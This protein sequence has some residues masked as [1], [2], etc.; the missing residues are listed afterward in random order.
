[1]SLPRGGGA[2]RGIGEKFSTNPATGTCSLNIP[3]ATSPGRAGFELSLELS[4]DSGSGNGPFGIGWH[5]STPSVSRKTDKG[6]P[7]YADEQDADIFV[8]S[9]AEDLVPVRVRNSDG[10]R[11]DILDRGDYRVQRYRQRTEG[12]FA[13]IERWTNRMNGDVHWRVITRENVLSIYGRSPAARIADPE[14][15]ER[16]FSWLIEETRDDRGNI[17][18]Y[19]YKPE[20][21]TGVDAGRASE[22]N[23][24]EARPDGSREFLATSQRYLKRIQ[25]GNLIPVANREVPAPTNEEDWLFEVVFDYGEHDEATPTPAE[26][27]PWPVREDPFSSFRATFDVRT[28]RLCRRILMFHRFAELGPTPCL[29]RSTDLAYDEGPVVTYL[30]AATQVGYK[31]AP[32]ANVYER[33]MLPPLELGYVKPEVYD[34]LR[35][36]EQ[37]SLEGIPAGI[38]GSAQWVD[39]DGEGIP[40]VLVRTDRTWF[41]KANLGEGRLAPPAL[42]RKLP[43]PAELRR[44]TD[45]LVDLGGDGNLDLVRYLPPLSGYFERTRDKDWAPFIPLTN[46]PNIDWSDPNLRFLDLNGDGLPDVLIT[47]H[48]AFVWYRSKARDGFEPAIFVSKPKDELKGSA[49]VFADRTETIQLAD[50]SGDGL[51]DIVRV[52]NGEVCYWPNL[53]YARFGR[54]VTLDQSPWFDKPDQFDPK[55]IRFADIDGSG[56]S[57]IAYLGREGVYLYFNES[58]NGLS[59]AQRLESLPPIDLASGLSVV[60]LLGRGTA[61]LVWSSPL[62]GNHTRPLTYVDVMG[63]KKPHVLERVVNNLG[64]ET[65]IAYA[66]SNKFYLKDKAEGIPWFTRLAFPVHVVERIERYDHVAN[67]KLVTTFAY[68][69]GYF[70]G[71]EREFRGFARVDQWDA[72]SFSDRKGKGLFPEVPDGAPENEDLDLPPVRTVTWFHTGAWLERERLE[73]ALATEYYGRDPVAQDSR[74]AEFFLPDTVFELGLDVNGNPEQL[75]VREEREAT[76]ALR[77][78]MLRQ[79]IYAEDGTGA[80]E[81]PYLVSER[82]YQVRLIQHAIDDYHGVFFVHPFHSLSLHYERVP[83]DPRIQHE[84]VLKVDAFGNVEKSAD[85]AYPRR[86]DGREHDETASGQSLTEQDRIWSTLTER[87][88]ANRAAEDEWYRI[89]VPV[90]T[91]TSEL[92]GLAAPAQGVLSAD[93]VLAKAAIA[94]EIPYEALASGGVQRRVVERQRAL[95]YRAYPDVAGYRNDALGPLPLGEITQQALPHQVYRQ[96]LTPGLVM[97]IYGTRVTDSM[98]RDEGQYVL[99]DGAWW[100]PSGRAIFDPALFFLAVEAVDPFGERHLLRYDD[101][102]LLVLDAEDPAHNHVTSGLRDSAGTI[103]RNGNDYRVLAPT[104]VCDPNRNRTVVDFDALGMVVKQWQMGREGANEGDGPDTPGVV[105][106]Y[107][108]DAWRQGNGPAFAHVATREVHRVGGD[109]FAQDGTPQR[110]GFQHARSYSDGLGREVMKKVQAE[111]GQVPIVDA[112]GH[113][114]HKPDG[115]PETRREENR[116]VGTGR[117]IF[118]NKGNPIKKYEPFFSG[119]IEYES[120]K[121]LVEWGVTPLLRYD[122]LGR[123][124]RTNQP[125]GTYALVVFD[126]W[127][128]ATWDENDT[129]LS[130]RWYEARGKPMPQ[131]PEPGDAERRAAWLAARHANT[132]SMACLDSL[133]RIFLTVVDNG[134]DANGSARR[135]ATRVKLDVEGNQFSITD[136]RG[137]EI[138][139]HTF[140][141]FARKIRVASVDAGE[142][143]TLFNVGDNRIRAWNPGDYAIRRDYDALQRPLHVWI[144][145][146]AGAEKLVERAVYGEEH[147]DTE[148]RNL[149]ARCYQTYDGAGVLTTARFDFKGNASESSRRLAREFRDHP[150]WSPLGTLTSPQA[151]EGVAS[152]LLEAEVLTTTARFDALNRVIS[153]VTP[154]GSDTRPVYNEAGLLESI[155]VNIRG[156]A[157][158]TTFV[159]HIDYNAR[160]QQEIIQYG[161]KTTTGY[162]YD[163][164]TFRL[165]HQVST[166]TGGSTLQD[167][168]YT[169]D[170]VGNIVAI[171]DAVSYGNPNISASGIYEYDALYR[172]SCA[173][174]REH[175]GQQ[176]TN[177]DAARL[178]LPPGAHP[179]DWQALRRYCDTYTYD[180]VGNILKMSHR[181]IAQST[182]A[183]TRGYQ[184][185]GN[186]NRLNGTSTPGDPPGTFSATYDH[187]AAGNIIRMP[188]LPEMDWDHANRLQ[189]V[190]KRIQPG[191]A[192]AND[193][194]FA[195]N[196][197]GQRVRKVYEHNGLI[198]ERI[199]LS[200]YEIYRKRSAIA[201]Q[202]QLERQTLHVMNDMK[203]IALVETKTVDTSASTFTA[204]TRYRFQLESHL[205]SSIIETDSSGG[206]ISYEEYSPYGSTTFHAADSSVDVSAKSYRYTGKERDTE[207]GLY[208]YGVRYYACWLGRW[209]SADPMGLVDGTCL[210]AYGRNNPVILID[211]TGKQAGPWEP[212]IRIQRLQEAVNEVVG[213]AVNTVSSV[214]D[215]VIEGDFHE[216]DTTWGGV[217]GNVG[218]GLIPYVGQAAD[219]RDTVANAKKVW[220]NPSSGWAWAGLGMAVVGWVPLFGDALKGTGK[221]GRKVGT[222]VLEKE[223]K[224]A[225]KAIEKEA[226]AA[227]ELAEKEAKAAKELAEKEAKV[228][229]ETAEKEA[230]KAAEKAV[231][232]ESEKFTV[233]RFMSKQELKQLKKEGVAFDPKKGSGIP[234]TTTNFTPK[235]QGVAKVKT[236][237]R[238]AEYQVDINATGLPR[239]PSRKTKAGLPEWPIQGDID[240]ERIVPGSIR[241]VPK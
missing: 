115:N 59:E 52:R 42:E 191:D 95:Y 102:A 25:Y 189:H 144:Q 165:T 1:V 151:I 22:S 222:E 164:E 188:H 20:D 198:E 61:C 76:R 234:T 205:G 241:K 183:W 36:I 30:T 159:E 70:D 67:T 194:Y 90:E 117:T 113:L 66:S 238:S 62:P 31:R 2:I 204:S 221:V 43:A 127:K 208:Y 123:L 193:V 139:A 106:R 219:A 212:Y 156:A 141:M 11:L 173:E 206:V 187:D 200:G 128:Q 69:H 213:P 94:A 93:E 4:Y 220:D 51:V 58:G 44:G 104:V 10:T 6:L 19:I 60:D 148:S 71:N 35:T 65:R 147:P 63:G 202:L 85:I 49:V 118:D 136:A 99:R 13:R 143:H 145:K 109:P 192:P 33:A 57:D 18:C 190:R 108:L 9:G 14:H 237:A 216:G 149:R 229:K 110:K 185:A 227:K 3:I 146:G 32:G 64:S 209:T 120:E 142:S 163:R 97:Q 107:E 45:Q 50:M 56:T 41:Y 92:T 114:V 28:Y 228:A 130:S 121:E 124:T 211:Q 78:L 55:R 16:I 181:P 98:L 172:L 150:D 138:S 73:I 87:T 180:P 82:N 72:E 24:F 197:S 218:V 112:N 81:H 119:T 168:T 233:R 103:T 132:P 195:Y 240:P 214:V 167:L 12:L 48:D 140:D 239:G 158:P 91:T 105:I 26:A 171:Q 230:K 153:R 177:E 201:S 68:H 166:R 210:Y 116:W 196:S 137:I 23:R 224:V 84:V 79:E 37:A 27:K 232:E 53:G 8:L 38:D 34:E 176:P 226:K 122:P 100:A 179:N 83:D 236:G 161:N 184:Y 178:G 89:G 126:A 199:Y 186:S 235:N 174:G 207:T 135:Y 162:D 215:Q 80:A 223:A 21:A 154:D 96:A 203:R 133:G 46:L 86:R 77:G 131:D 152:S 40:G 155:S 217:A 160:G 125:N 17:A 157:T 15:P 5:L 88:F 54:K 170:P 111:P 225:E 39:L 134:K 29:V 175:P 182:G 169:H 75:S 231:E 47:E 7:Q 74:A 101:Y 129:V